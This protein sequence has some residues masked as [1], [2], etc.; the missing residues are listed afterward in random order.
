MERRSRARHDGESTVPRFGTLWRAPAWITLAFVVLWGCGGGARGANGPP[1]T[2][3]DHTRGASPAPGAIVVEDAPAGT[4]SA[5][6]GPSPIPVEADDAVWGSPMAPV[7]IV[8]FFDLQ[9]PFCSRAQPTLDALMKRYGPEALR[10]AYKHNPLPFHKSALPAARAAQV[11]RDVGG[12]DASVKFIRLALEGQRDLSEERL[13]RWASDVGVPPDTLTTQDASAGAAVQRDMALAKALTVRGTPAFRINGQLVSGAQPAEKFQEVIDRELAA[14]R[15][16]GKRGIGS[17]AVYIERVKANLAAEAAVV[18]EAPKAQPSPF[19]PPDLDLTVHRVPITGSPVQGT[20]DALVT[21]V[22]FSEFQCPFCQKVQATLKELKQRHGRELRFVFKHNPLPFHPNA[23]PAAL[24]AAEAR[25]QRGDAGFWDAHDRL[26]ARAP[27]LENADLLAIGEAMRL[28][29]A[30]VRAALDKKTHDAAIQ[31][32]MDLALDIEARGTPQ[33]FING[34]RLSGAQPIDQFETLIAV[35][36]A[37]ARKLVEA[38]VPRMR[39]YAEIMKTAVGP[40]P[41]E[42]KRVP[43]PTAQHP[44]RG[45]ANAKVVIQV[46]SDFECPFC[47]RVAPTIEELEKA[48]PGRLRVVWRNL[49]LPFHKHARLAA[50]AALEAQ[51]QQG[52]KGFWRMHDK[53]FEEQEQG[54]L[55]SRENVVRWARELKLDVTRLEKALDQKTHEP[56]ID[57]DANVADAAGITGTPSFLV[58]DYF[59]VGAQPLGAFRKLVRR[60]LDDKRA[61]PA[62]AR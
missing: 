25:A 55:L 30:R 26:F 35:E 37:K 52:I 53:L 58:N 36:L 32:D 45:P 5:D 54:N 3:V 14:A 28:N 61:P 48:Y 2:E 15:E 17:G 16:L 20:A 31:T 7:T 24:F 57:A 4:P 18:A 6:P 51:A 38:G 21:I 22:M 29:G 50:A 62:L 34:R 44:S 23:M 12:P 39:V 59:I 8:A 27:A 46:F 49:P 10:V 1:A 56:A 47:R 33:F 43:A 42:T 11:V 13:R 19:T 9:D 40:K 60:A 41:P